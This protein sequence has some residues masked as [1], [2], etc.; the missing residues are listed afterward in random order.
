MGHK[1]AYPGGSS[2]LPQKRGYLPSSYVGTGRTWGRDV[3][4]EWTYENGVGHE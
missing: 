3:G 2:G 1:M 4:S